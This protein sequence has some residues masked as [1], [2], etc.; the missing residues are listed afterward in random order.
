MNHG[1]TEASDW[2]KGGVDEFGYRRI[3]VNGKSVREHRVV[4][5]QKLGR[6]LLPHENVHH[7][8]GNRLDNR[9]ENLELW[10]TKQPKG[11]RPED[12]VAWAKEILAMYGDLDA[13][14]CN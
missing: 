5:E 7:I 11:Q 12:L 1:T 9:P 8:N 2:G 4:M 13:K 14:Q 10:V 3:K 6:K